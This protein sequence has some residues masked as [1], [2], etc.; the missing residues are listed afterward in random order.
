MQLK[1]LADFLRWAQ[2]S[3][4]DADLSF[5]HG[6]DN[7]WDEA[8]SLATFVLNLPIDSDDRVLSRILTRA[9]RQQLLQLSHERIHRR[10]PVPYLSRVCY[11][12]GLK[13]YIDERAIIPRSPIAEL[14]IN[15]F[16]PWLRDLHR[17]SC[18]CSGS[19]SDSD[20]DS[21]SCSDSD[22][23]PQILDLCCG[24]GCI[25]IACAHFFPGSQ[26]E[27][28]DISTEALAVA[29]H[30]VTLYGF[31]DRVLLKQSDLFSACAGQQYDLIVSNPPYVST[32]EMDSLPREYQWEPDL[33]LRAGDLG[34]SLVDRILKEAKQYL[35]PDGLLIVEVGAQ[36]AAVVQ[37]HYSH[38]PLTWLE[39]EHGGEG[40]FLVEARDQQWDF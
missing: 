13:F 40:V 36:T 3:F 9:E 35:K 12:A 22:Q 33:A 2:Q 38:L 20:S 29:A 21:C 10:K 23:K 39:F 30:N 27:A 7:A 18:S 28:V 34:L 1:T 17:F 14:I 6:T 11:F 15:G 4:V 37:Q 31:E 19:D 24:S 5:G 25:G 8:V 32:E 26:V 16:Q